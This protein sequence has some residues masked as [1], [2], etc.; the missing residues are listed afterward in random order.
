MHLRLKF[1]EILSRLWT[2][3]EQRLHRNSKRCAS[4][5]VLCFWPFLKFIWGNHDFFGGEGCVDH[6][7]VARNWSGRGETF[8]ASRRGCHFQLQQGERCSG[9]S[10]NGSAKARDARGSVQSGCEQTLRKQKISRTDDC[11][12]GAA[13]YSGGKRRCVEC[14]RFADREDDGKAVGRNDAN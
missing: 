6:G 12:V 4:T 8:C 7:G 10:G 14:G 5:Y 11:A 2:R 1:L 13:G 9:S 3:V